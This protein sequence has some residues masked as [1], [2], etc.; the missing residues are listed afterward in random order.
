MG[1]YGRALQG[2]SMGEIELE[3]DCSDFPAEFATY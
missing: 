1:T 2:V 3:L